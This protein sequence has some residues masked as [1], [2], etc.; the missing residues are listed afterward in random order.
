[1]SDAWTFTATCPAGHADAQQ[2]FDRDF[3]EGSLRFGAPLRFYCARC[4]Q[5]WNATASQREVLS[6][7]ISSAKTDRVLKFKKRMP[8]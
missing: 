2:S 1:M 3:L 8:A 7:A 5:H 6:G 4:H